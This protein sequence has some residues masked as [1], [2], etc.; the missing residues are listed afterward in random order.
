M[1]ERFTKL[2]K[3]DVVRAWGAFQNSH[4][5]II[6]QELINRMILSE[7]SSFEH[8]SADKFEAQKAKIEGIRQVLGTLSL[9]EDITL[10]TLKL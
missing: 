6:L 10:K 8:I 1:T 7:L 4:S 5:K 3:L 9:P 2:D